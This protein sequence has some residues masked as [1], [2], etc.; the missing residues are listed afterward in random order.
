MVVVYRAYAWARIQV[1]GDAPEARANALDI[2]DL[3]RALG[4]FHEETVQEWFVELEAFIVFWNFFHG[5]FHFLVPGLVFLLL[6]RRDRARYRQWRNVFGWMLLVG[7]VTFAVYPL[8]PPRFF[9]GLG[10]V[11][12]RD[13]Y[14]GIGPFGT[15]APADVG[16]AFAAMPSLHVGWAVWAPFAVMPVLR[17]REWKVLVILHPVA[18]TFAVVV[19]GNHWVLDAVGGALALVLA[20]AMERARAELIARWRSRRRRSELTPSGSA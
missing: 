1:R 3:E 6:Y 11:D 5:L 8:A 20:Y 18:M 13:L 17:R 10:F 14:G 15:P 7:L 4:I 12:T 16:N 9:E 19:T 2:V